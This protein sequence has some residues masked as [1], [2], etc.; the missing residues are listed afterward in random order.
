[1]STC[2]PRESPVDVPWEHRTLPSVIDDAAQRYGDRVALT[3]TDGDEE[4]TFREVRDRARR[5]GS[6]LR[7][8]AQANG[9]SRVMTVLDNHV[10]HVVT[11]L[12][13][14]YAQLASVP[15]NPEATSEA[16][17]QFL[18][19]SG[20]RILVVEA[21]HLELVER[22]VAAERIEGVTVVVRGATEHMPTG[23]IGLVDWD[24]VA[25]TADDID[26]ERDGRV[27]P[28]DLH[29]VM[30]TSGSTGGPKSVLIP[31]AQTVTRA[32]V[33]D[34]RGRRRD[35][36][37]ALVT[38]PLFHVAGQCRGVLGPL[39]QGM[40]VVIA[41]RFS[42]TRFWGWIEQHG[43]TST[44]LMG[45]MMEY[46]LAS[47]G[48]AAGTLEMLSAAPVTPRAAEF[49]ER[50]GL[51]I[52]ATY[53]STEAGTVSTGISTRVGSLGWV[54]P[55][56]EARI[57]DEH[58]VDVPA[59]EAGEL[60]LRARLPWLMTPGY[61]H[62]DAATVALWRNQWLHTGDLV[63]A[64]PD[65]ELIFVERAK[66]IIRANGENIAPA[67]L[68]ALVLDVPG[69]S[70]CVA[71]GVATDAGDELVKIV[72]VPSGEDH[73][74]ERLGT[75]L[76]GRIPRYMFPTLVE[77]VDEIPRTPTQKTRK[78]DLKAQEGP[79]IH[80]LRAYRPSRLA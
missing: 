54:H 51:D 36:G 64:E 41:P 76:A 3:S 34:Q 12:G 58:D 74:P 65:G 53:G 20:A 11:W 59:G 31:H 71:L 6:G 27:A 75:E 21:R 26:D 44:L 24:A 52:H 56:Y 40:T 78:G 79:R 61:E 50:F 66:D 49:A 35:V 80:D 16:L 70:E 17:G 22:A 46:L 38:V 68:E 1:M 18:R 13:I 4:L 43:V 5:I 19:Q 23:A 29:S 77:F 62:N 67:D 28:W 48:G 55:D 33:V 14:A 25:A 69:V 8:L 45:S 9:S 32:M 39:M 42:V 30:F 10:P 57:V 73:A 47:P 7:A 60:V 37:A 15:V 63:R 72:I 2:A